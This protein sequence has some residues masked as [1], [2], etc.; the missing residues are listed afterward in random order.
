MMSR[1]VVTYYALPSPPVTPESNAKL[2]DSAGAKGGRSHVVVRWPTRL[3]AS[4]KS[5]L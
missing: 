5:A 3:M 4:E 2:R 1:I